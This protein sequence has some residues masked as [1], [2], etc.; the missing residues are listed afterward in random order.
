VPPGEHEVVVA[1]LLRD[2]GIE[3]W[4][5]K[6]VKV[7]SGE[8]VNMTCNTY[9]ILLYYIF[10]IIFITPVRVQGLRVWGLEFRFRSGD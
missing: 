10:V 5:D 2:L 9:Y 8:G 7:Y 1:G 3:G 6:L 4:A